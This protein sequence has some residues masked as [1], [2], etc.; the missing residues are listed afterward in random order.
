MNN[1]SLIT[2]TLPSTA[3]FGSVIAIVGY[4]SG[5]WSIAQNSG[6]TIHFGNVNT[7]TGVGGSLSSTNRY[8]CVELLCTVADTAFVVRSSIGNITYV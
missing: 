6:Q 3:A 2:G 8:D 4:G 7:T 5:G 1:G